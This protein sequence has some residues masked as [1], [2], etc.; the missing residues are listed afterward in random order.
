MSY[1]RHWLLW[2]GLLMESRIVYEPPSD[3]VSALCDREITRRI[4]E[5]LLANAIKFKGR[6]G[7]VR[8]CLSREERG[9]KVTV[10]DRGPCIPPEYHHRIFEKFGQVKTK[11]EGKSYSTGL[12]LTFCKLAVEAQGGRIGLDSEVG[13]GSAFWFMIPTRPL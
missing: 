5:N 8:I 12:G 3:A 10:S 9:M 2:G 6:G 13:K 1:P 4:V 11:Q 7:G